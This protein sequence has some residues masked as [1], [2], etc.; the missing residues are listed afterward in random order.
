MKKYPR[1]PDEEMRRGQYPTK[2]RARQAARERD[3]E[4]G[5]RVKHRVVPCTTNRID[6]VTGE[7]TIYACYT[8]VLEA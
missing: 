7:N 4:L 6:R 2:A 1:L 3:S 5:F 8:V